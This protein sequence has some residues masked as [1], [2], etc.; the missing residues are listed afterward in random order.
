[1][2]ARWVPHFLSKDLK[3]QRVACSHKLL[4]EFEPNGP[5]R[6][7]D[8]VAGDESWLMSYGIPIKR[9]NSMWVGSDG[10]RQLVFRPGFQ[11]HKWPFSN[12]FSTHGLV[13]LNILPE[14]S[15]ITAYYYTQVVPPSVVG[16]VHEQR[17][18]ANAQKTLLLY[19]NASAHKAKVNT[20]FMS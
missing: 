14:K 4:Y 8:I 17:L 15:K 20:T 5:K 16:K 12:F 3:K 9:V 7:C 13:T 6:L 2:V 10:D 1:M 19:E 11:G 18:T